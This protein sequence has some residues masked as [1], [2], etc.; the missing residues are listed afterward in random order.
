MKSQFSDVYAILL[1]NADSLALSRAQTEALQG[2]QKVL[3]ARA[4]SIFAGVAAYLV[5]L[6]ENYSVKEAATRV[7][8]AGDSVWQVIYRERDF[9]KQT[10]TPGQIVLLPAPI[11]DMVV[12]PDYRGRF[13]FGF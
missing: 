13:F 6:P 1:R 7:T 8:A 3:R 12:T 2:E 5:G 9:L 10:L 11:R 4:D